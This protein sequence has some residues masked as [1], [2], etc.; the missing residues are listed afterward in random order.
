MRTGTSPSGPGTVRFSTLATSS[1]GPP[2]SAKAVAA[3]RASDGDISFSGGMPEASICSRRPAAAG[4][5]GMSRTSHELGDGGER[6]LRLLEL[7]HVR[8]TFEHLDARAGNR[9]L[10]FV[11]VDARDEPVLVAPDD[12]RRRRYPVEPLRQTP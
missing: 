5:R 1:P 11:G 12:Q 9:P 3:W 8:R 2:S 10:E 4:S 7:R 6:T